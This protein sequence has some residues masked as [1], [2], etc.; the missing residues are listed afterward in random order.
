MSV[1]SRVLVTVA[2][3]SCLSGCWFAE[4]YG[5][6]GMFIRNDTASPVLVVYRPA[7][8]DPIEQEVLELAAGSGATTLG[9][10]QGREEEC[11]EG[12]L[13]AIQDGEE[14]ATLSQPCDG[15]DWVIEPEEP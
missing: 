9:V 5:A 7:G 4:D 2:C 11:A 13:V 15:S 8:A 10:H 1:V 6:E 14:I 12:T 3:A